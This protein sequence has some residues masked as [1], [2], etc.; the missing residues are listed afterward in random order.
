M[1][2]FLITLIQF[3]LG[4]LLHFVYDI[5]NFSLIG[6]FAPI[7]ESIFEHVKLVFYPMII[8]GVI[9]IIY[10]KKQKIYTLTSLFIGTL[11]ASFSMFF[12]YYFYRYGLGIESMYYDIGL[13]F[14]VQAIGNIVSLIIYNHKFEL[15]DSVIIKSIIIVIILIVLCTFLTPDIPMF[16]EGNPVNTY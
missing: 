2:L 9:V 4:A 7:N 5:F 8:I 15:K 6:T 11:V 14:V 1:F 13:L 12:I 3:L 16:I 10:F